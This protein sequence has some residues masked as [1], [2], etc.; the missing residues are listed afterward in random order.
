[1]KSLLFLFGSFFF[2][3][4]QAC[5]Q[6]VEIIVA[7][8]SNHTPIP[9]ATIG[10]TSGS[11]GFYSDIKGEFPRKLLND[12]EYEITCVG[13]HPKKINP[14]EVKDT[15]FLSPSEVKLREVEVKSSYKPF[16][17]GYLQAHSSDD[18]SLHANPVLTA[19]IECP[20]GR[21]VKIEQI[22]IPF[23][24]LRKGDQFK[25]LLFKV[26]DDGSPGSLLFSRDFS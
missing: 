13:Y 17:I 16:E 1:M 7:D 11:D 5:G 22:I 6:K 2:V 9:F 15:I 8:S 24:S 19:R 18:F 20:K 21:Q 12:K 14:A 3:S 26:K 23:K 4:I 25:V 10:S